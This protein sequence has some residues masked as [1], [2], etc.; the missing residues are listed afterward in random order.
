[1]FKF[2][3]G[4]RSEITRCP[5]ISGSDGFTAADL[6]ALGEVQATA[7]A[8]H[9]WG[10]GQ[11]IANEFAHYLAIWSHGAGPAEPPM[12]AL[13][14]FKKTGTYMLMIGTTIVASG[15]RLRDVLPALPYAV[16]RGNGSA[17]ATNTSD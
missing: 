12:L 16:A 4:N 6:L 13:A 5:A 11:L 15:R 2:H 10:R 3:D 1:M 17:A 14:R 7:M 9:L 8:R